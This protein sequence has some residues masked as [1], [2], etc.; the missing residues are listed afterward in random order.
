[1][2]PVMA[3]RGRDGACRAISVSKHRHHDLEPCSRLDLPAFIDGHSVNTVTT[4]VI[5]VLGGAEL[6]LGGIELKLEMRIIRARCH[7]I[8]Q[9]TYNGLEGYLCLLVCRSYP[10]V[11]GFATL[12]A[13]PDMIVAASKGFPCTTPPATRTKAVATCSVVQSLLPIVR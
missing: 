9:S 2:E 13:L 5:G 1:M 7:L 10:P 8:P 11:Q 12:H 6:E 3:F 4:E